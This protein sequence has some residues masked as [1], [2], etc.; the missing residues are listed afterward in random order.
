MAE[1]CCIVHA[2]VLLGVQYLFF[3][4]MPLSLLSHLPCS[5]DLPFFLRDSVPL[6]L[7]SG[8][9]Q[10]GRLIT[11]TEGNS[12]KAIRSH[13]LLLVGIS[14]DAAI[15]GLKHTSPRRLLAT[16]HHTRSAYASVRHEL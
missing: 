6:S 1:Y 2:R 14:Y 3:K 7:V 4:E 16:V 8:I 5:E 9:P 15:S 12:C 11:F 13:C 10:R